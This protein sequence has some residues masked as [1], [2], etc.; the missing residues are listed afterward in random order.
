MVRARTALFAVAI[1]GAAMSSAAACSC[2]RSNAKSYSE[3]QAWQLQRAED[4]V[5]G[6]IVEVRGAEHGGE[7]VLLAKMVVTSVIKGNVPVGELTL[8]SI[9]HEAGCG[10]PGVILSGFGTT[11]DI[12]L[13]VYKDAN[14]EKTYR[15][16][17]CG[18]RELNAPLVKQ[19]TR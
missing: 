19:L 10:V 2:E 7:R 9:L 5:A 4:V 14:A 6:R 15:V 16:N 8:V 3:A 12:A 17:Y 18:Y 1:L 11:E 13:Q